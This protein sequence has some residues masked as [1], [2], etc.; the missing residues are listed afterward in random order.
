[1]GRELHRRRLKAEASETARAPDPSSHR[2]AGSRPRPSQPNSDATSTTQY[3]FYG[4]AS[5][6]ELEEKHEATSVSMPKA[7][8]V[9][10][11][12]HDDYSIGSLSAQPTTTYPPLG[13]TVDE[14]LQ[15]MVVLEGH[16]RMSSLPAP[17]LASS[18]TLGLTTQQISI[19]PG[20]A[21]GRESVRR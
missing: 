9:T 8:S 17:Q 7:T 5:L 4:L 1:M 12:A 15:R 16:P 13:Q 14:L 6:N 19:R 3:D 2:G 10:I 11:P 20:G 21:S 18:A